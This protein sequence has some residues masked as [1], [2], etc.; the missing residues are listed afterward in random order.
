[1]KKSI[2][3]LLI[4]A[5]VAV[6]IESSGLLWAQTPP[7]C[8]GVTFDKDY[9]DYG[10]PIV[11]T[12]TVTNCSNPPTS[13]LINKGFKSMIGYLEMRLID[14]AGRLLSPLRDEEHNEF[15]D[16]QPL[17]FVL[18]TTNVPVPVAPCEVLLPGE[19]VTSHTDDLRKY[20]P[21]KFPGHYSAQVQLSAMTFKASMGAPGEEQ[22]NVDDYEWV[23]AFESETKYVYAHG[24]SEV[25]IIP[26]YW[27][28][29]WKDGKYLIPE[30][31]VAIWPEEGKTV[32][33]YRKDHIQ[34]NN[35][36]A[37]NVVKMY[38]ILRKKNYLLALFDK[39]KAI[40]SL[41][42]VEKGHWYPVVISGMLKTNQFFGGG[43]NVRIIS[44][45]D[46]IP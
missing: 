33:D 4:I 12:V 37:K 2:L 25:D 1:M 20:Y 36:V 21:I 44:F 46:L 19:S 13:I 26:K 18:D 45:G 39:R 29:E 41:G 7:I 8:V 11:V 10:D 22:C 14:P 30:I 23:G 17:A 15:P 43:Q 31:A 28:F 42:T 38:S 32:D 3:S 9:Y 27:F 5:G 40:N 34:L 35:V 16:A 6:F 24:S